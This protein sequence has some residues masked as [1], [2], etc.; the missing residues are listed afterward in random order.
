MKTIR[1]IVL[2]VVLLQ[3]LGFLWLLWQL[4]VFGNW[5]L[6]SGY[7][8]QFN[9]VK[10]V[11]E[12]MPGVV[13]V[14]HWQHHDVSLEDFGFALLIEGDRKAQVNFTESSPQIKERNKSKLRAFIRK[15]ID[16]NNVLSQPSE[17]RAEA[18][19]PESG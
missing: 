6:E 14:D 16:S 19:L 12:E 17:S 5:G 7:Y 4:G 15:E 9:R 8:G 18:C 11:I 3:V 13:I 1:K 2:G 10:H